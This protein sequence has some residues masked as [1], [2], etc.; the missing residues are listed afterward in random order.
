MEKLTPIEMSRK[1]YVNRVAPMIREK[2]PEYESRI[3][4]GI[5]GEG[6]DCFGYD[7]FISRDHDYAP[8][9]CLWL[10]EELKALFDRWFNDY[11]R[12]SVYRPI[13]S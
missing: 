10:P 13:A 1:F 7:D 9:F 4:V 2:F 6:S 3:A 8:G 11:L 12:G 5:A